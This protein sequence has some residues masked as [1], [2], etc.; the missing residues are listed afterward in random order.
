MRTHWLLFPVAALLIAGTIA[1]STS[2]AD[3]R[4]LDVADTIELTGAG[5][6][7]P[8]PLYMKWFEEY[9]KT[10]P[11]VRI[12]YQPLGSGAGIRQMVDGTVFFGATD[13]PMTDAQLAAAPNAVLHLPTVI[14]ANVPIYNVPQITSDLRFT[15]AVLAAIF[16]G[17][18][19]TWNDPKIAALNAGVALPD[20]PISVMHRSDA[21]GTT[22]IWS[23]YLSKVSEDWRGI[24]G[25]ST[26]IQWPI[27]TGVRGNEGVANSVRDTVGAI[28]YVELVYALQ[29]RITYG[30]VQ[31]R[32]GEF[33]KAS[34]AS[35]TAAAAAAAQE[36]PDDFRVSITD[37]LGT[38][39]YPISS[40]TWLLLRQDPTD[41]MRAQ[42]MVSFMK[43]ALSEGQR[44]AAPMGYAPLPADIIRR[45]LQA[46]SRIN[47]T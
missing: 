39:A 14:G 32:S 37:P 16:L 12:N 47:A 24:A 29:Q 27:G 40:F 42:S 1:C 5:A 6:T 7:F 34:E 25:A 41:K 20:L 3:A 18:I 30:A 21:S 8:Y 33:V 23:D 38:G 9:G 11:E 17:E 4:R 28:G 2:G 19:K 10:H 13:G 43:W 15:G 46:L 44:F 36:T 22:Y 26:S 35:L 31:N 45:E